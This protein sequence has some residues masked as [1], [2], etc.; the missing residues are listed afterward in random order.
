VLFEM[1]MTYTYTVPDKDAPAIYGT[2]D[3]VE[4]A[5][6]AADDPGAVLAFFPGDLIVTRVVPVPD[7]F[8]EGNGPLPKVLERQAPDNG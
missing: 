3:P 6:Q 1:Q 2:S 7:Y 5:R 8:P 4:C